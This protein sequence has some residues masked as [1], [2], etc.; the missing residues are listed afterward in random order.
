M[1]D[2][3]ALIPITDEQAKLGQEV[4]KALSGLGSFLGDA[5][6]STPK[7]L[8]GYLGGDWLRLRRAKNIAEM[9]N[10]TRK[11]LEYLGA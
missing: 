8:I 10:R 2:D 9:L 5:L 7:D 11:Q 6:G 1:A 4:V 3:C